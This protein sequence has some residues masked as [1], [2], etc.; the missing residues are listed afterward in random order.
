MTSHQICFRFITCTDLQGFWNSYFW[1]RFF[2]WYSCITRRFCRRVS[3]SAKLFKNKDLGIARNCNFLANESTGRYI[4]YLFQ[5]DLLEASC[6]E[7]LLNEAKRSLGSTLIFLIERFY[8]SRLIPR[9]ARIFS[10]DVRIYRSIGTGY[11]LCRTENC[12]LKTQTSWIPD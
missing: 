1:R 6:I 8:L 2:W 9:I 7:V 11:V 10:T 5:D 4:K 12:I 3:G